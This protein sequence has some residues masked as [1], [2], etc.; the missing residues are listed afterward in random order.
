MHLKHAVPQLSAL[1]AP[2]QLVPWKVPG[3]VLQIKDPDGGGRDLGAV[4]RRLS[5]EPGGRAPSHVPPT[6]G[7]F[8]LMLHGC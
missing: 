7:L 3:V 2:G 4:L 6:P 8:T 1:H 5:C